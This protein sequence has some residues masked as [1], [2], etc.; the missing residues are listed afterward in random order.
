MRIKSILATFF[1]MAVV[2]SLVILQGCAGI[3]RQLESPDISLAKIS[4]QEAKA[5]ETTFELDLRVFNTNDVPL[6]IK[7]IDCE[8]EINGNKWAKGVSA[9]Q[10]KVPAF[11]TELVR[12]VVYSS[13]LGMVSSM[14][15]MIRSTQSN[16]DAPRLNYK[17]SGRLNIRGD[18]TIPLRLPFKSQGELNLEGFATGKTPS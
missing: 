11:G 18:S 13:M 12:M 5:F 7:G 4:I 3:G 17:I 10:T 2:A 6:E 1:C 15:D 14:L 9:T 16:Q 8:L